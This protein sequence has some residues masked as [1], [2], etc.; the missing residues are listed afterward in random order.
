MKTRI[1]FTVAPHAPGHRSRRGQFVLMEG[2][3]KYVT[4]PNVSNA[5]IKIK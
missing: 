2:V 1:S 3:S 5:S 4:F